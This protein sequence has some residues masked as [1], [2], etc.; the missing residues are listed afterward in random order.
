MSNTYA[1]SR[2]DETL[3][4]TSRLSSQFSA[5]SSSDVALVTMSSKGF[6]AANMLDLL[7]TTSIV[8]WPRAAGMETRDVKGIVERWM[9][10][11]KRSGVGLVT[12][13]KQ[14]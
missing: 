8:E 14:S 10:S 12:L 13:C 6:F 11:T 7:L 3:S 9:L 1:G 2:P 4:Q 5:V